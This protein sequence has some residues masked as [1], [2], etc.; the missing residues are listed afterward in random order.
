MAGCY[1]YRHVYDNGDE[2]HYYLCRYIS[3]TPRLALDSEE[4]KEDPKDNF[5]KPGWHELKD[6]PDMLV[7]PLEIRD[8]L[9]EDIRN[10]F[11]NTPKEAKLKISELRQEL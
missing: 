2:Q 7:Y 8:W 9:L 6:L 1:L 11:K 4:A 5:F 3:G 10:D